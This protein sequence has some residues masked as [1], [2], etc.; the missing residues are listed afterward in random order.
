MPEMHILHCKRSSLGSKVY[1]IL[2]VYICMFSEFANLWWCVILSISS[3]VYALCMIHEIINRLFF[4]DTHF[5]FL[6]FL[7]GIHI[8]IKSRI[9]PN[10][11]HKRNTF[12]WHFEPFRYIYVCAN[13]QNMTKIEWKH[14]TLLIHSD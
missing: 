13:V 10:K 8:M 12:A 4:M 6:L 9:E 2:H 11:N 5:L 7:P 14:F 1:N 3:Q